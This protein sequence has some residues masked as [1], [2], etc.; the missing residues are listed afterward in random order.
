M[1]Q[2]G[3]PVAKLPS[4]PQIFECKCFVFHLFTRH[5]LINTF[6]LIG[7]YNPFQNSALFM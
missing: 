7:P 6:Y 1:T 4:I 2:Y 5:C 3:N